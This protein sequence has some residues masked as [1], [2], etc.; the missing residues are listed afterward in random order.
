[1][2]GVERSRCGK[3]SVDIPAE[4]TDSKARRR[5]QNSTEFSQ[6]TVRFRLQTPL[7]MTIQQLFA[8]CRNVGCLV[9][10]EEF[11]SR[12]LLEKARLVSQAD[13][14]EISQRTFF[15]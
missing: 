11:L 14:I 4:Q 5:Q 8:D 2:N 1:M 9:V 3:P 13:E 7:Y 15:A 12:C 10:V 6:G